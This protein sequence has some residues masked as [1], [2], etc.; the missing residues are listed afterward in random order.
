MKVVVID[1]GAYWEC[2][3]QG[4]KDV[5]NKLEVIQFG[6]PKNH[7]FEDSVEEAKVNFNEELSV[8]GFLWDGDV[9]V[10]P[11]AKEG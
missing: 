10:Y 6:V 5:A 3:K 11:C 1:V 2:H 8:V 4:C 9:K 7:W